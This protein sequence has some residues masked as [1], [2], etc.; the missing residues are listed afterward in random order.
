MS[1]LSLRWAKFRRITVRVAIAVTISAMGVVPATADASPTRPSGPARGDIVKELDA[2]VEAGAPGVIAHVR[3]GQREW[4]LA[5]GESDLWTHRRARV[6]DRVRIGSVTKTY[7]AVLLLQLAGEGRLSLDDSVEKWLPG[8]VRGHGNDGRKITIRMLL[9]H[10]S[11]LPDYLADV[12]PMYFT[13]GNWDTRLSP[14]QLVAKAMDHHPVYPPGSDSTYSNTGYVLAGM[15]IEAVSKHSLSQEL[16][17]R[18]TRPLRLTR[19]TY[20]VHDQRIRGPHMEG[21]LS[22]FYYQF[23]NVTRLSP[24]WA[25]G[26]GAII[27]TPAEVAAFHHAVFSGRLL[28]P[29][30]LKEL[31][32]VVEST[33][34]PGLSNG[35]GFGPQEIC[36]HRVWTKDGQYPGYQTKSFISRDGQRQ[37]VYTINSDSFALTNKDVQRAETR[38]VKAVFCT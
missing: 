24:D 32:T 8:V 29:D 6:D 28:G 33:S 38:M 22:N 4:N 5:A 17:Q 34:Y 19:T 14:Q 7:I 16:R 20:P 1:R 25:A 26:A 11:G 13:T 15:V 21:Y 31:T 36:G 10:S 3:D 18:I 23:Q 35:L 9:N 27:S 30:Q 12:F 37:L 2:I